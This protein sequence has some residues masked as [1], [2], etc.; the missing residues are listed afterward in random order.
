[1]LS[2]PLIINHADCT[3][4]MPTLALEIDPE[5]PNQPSPFRHMVIHSQLCLDM[6]AQMSLRSD[7][8]TGKIAEAKRL[9]DAILNFFKNLPA[10]Y[11]R[12][13]PNTQWDAEFDWVVFQR[14]YLHLIGYM[15]LFS[16]LKP[17]VTRDSGEVMTEDEISL[18]ES[19]VQA[20]L[21][22]M[23]IS[24]GFFENLVTAGA[25]F[26]YAIFCIFDTATAMCSAFVY[27][28]SRN[29]PQRETVL[30]AIQKG[31]KMLEEARAES[32]TTSDLHR[33][34]KRLLADLPLSTKEK[35]VLGS[36]KRSRATDPAAPARPGV[37]ASRSPGG[38]GLARKILSDSNGAPRNGSTSSRSESTL[39]DTPSLVKSCGTDLVSPT[40]ERRSVNDSGAAL[41]QAH[42]DSSGLS[43]D[44]QSRSRISPWDGVVPSND[45][46]SHDARIP[47]SVEPVTHFGPSAGLVPNGDFVSRD[48]FVQPHGSPYQQDFTLGPPEQHH[49]NHPNWQQP[50]NFEM[51]VNVAQINEMGPF[52]EA[53]P[54]VLDYWDWQVLGFGPP[55]AWGHHQGSAS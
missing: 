33:I 29:L 49:F 54:S 42:P 47:P 38:D 31:V 55:G 16:I 20:A 9:R 14:R 53:V 46:L 3:F 32:K 52:G 22:L 43:A 13:Q 34:L 51:A 41:V 12:A 7:G 45:G 35:G 15:A 25:K 50:S 44:H 23:D 19:G 11:A 10:E 8:E 26:H 5:R 39:V 37:S 18:R 2:R 24:W 40:N 27:D 30:E 21:D 1:M 48:G 36:A 28:K 6:T 4:E 17:F